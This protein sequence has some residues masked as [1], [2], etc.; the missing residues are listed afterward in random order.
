MS[1]LLSEQVGALQRVVRAEGGAVGH[2]KLHGVLSCLCDE[3]TDLAEACVDWMEAELEGASLVVGAGGCGASEGMQM[4][5]F[6]P[7]PPKRSEDNEEVEVRETERQR[8]RI[9]CVNASS[10]SLHRTAAAIDVCVCVT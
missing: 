9:V 5:A 1:R 8:V 2:V 10:G 6:V 4:R 3:R 7:N